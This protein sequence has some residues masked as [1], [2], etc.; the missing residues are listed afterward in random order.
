[1]IALTQNRFSNFY[2]FITFLKLGCIAFG[3]PAAHIVLFHNFL[4]KRSSWLDEQEYFKVLALAQIIPGP[5]SSQVGIA[6]GYLKNGYSGAFCAWLGFTLPSA[7]LMTCAAVLGQYFFTSLNQHFFHVIQLIVLAVVIFA[8]WQM[9]RSLCQ[10]FW[11]YL[12]MLFAMI[13]IYVVPV[14]ANQI[15][16][17]LIAAIV[18]LFLAKA[19]DPQHDVENNSISFKATKAYM[20]LIVFIVPF[21]LFP[22]LN[23]LSPSLFL[24]AF[25]GFY[26]SASLVFGG[27]HIILPMLHQDFVATDLVANESFDLGYA[28]VQLMPGPL[29]SFA[30]YLGALLPFTSSV[31]VNASLATLMIYIPSFL[32]I[33]ATLPYWSWFMQQQTIYKAIQGIHAAVVGLL[34]CLIVQMTEK[35][36]V[37]WLDLLFVITIIALLKSKLPIWLTLIGSFSTYYFYLNSVVIS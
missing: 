6:I 5:T 19:K 25:E 7:I 1:M 23:H 33:F 22:I 32:L 30:S 15:I 12:L 10:Y 2:I 34:L 17:I 28:I 20:W 14:S 35:Y 37:Q 29:F 21:L 36:I 26:R 16:V 3:G 8:F 27:G 11:Q 13:F 18:G 31:V 4:I 24:Q 9:L